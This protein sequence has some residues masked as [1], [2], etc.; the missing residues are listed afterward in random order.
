MLCELITFIH[1]HTATSCDLWL[2]W[3]LCKEKRIRGNL[4]KSPWT[5]QQIMVR[6]VSHDCSHVHVELADCCNIFY[7]DFLVSDVHFWSKRKVKSS[8]PWWDQRSWPVTQYVLVMI[9]YVEANAGRLAHLVFY[10]VPM[11][12]ETQLSFSAFKSIR[13]MEV[14]RFWRLE[15]LFTN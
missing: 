3:V 6:Q 7:F 15:V 10:V 12:F 14:E 5:A 8:R 9:L 11:L 1:T 2:S 13:E 4:L